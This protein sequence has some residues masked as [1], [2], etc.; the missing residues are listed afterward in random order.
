MKKWLNFVIVAIT[1]L[2]VSIIIVV[3]LRVNTL[4][5]HIE[6]LNNK[7]V[8]MQIF[9]QFGE[10]FTVIAKGGKYAIVYNDISRKVGVIDFC[11]KWLLQPEF[12]N[13][14]YARGIFGLLIIEGE[15]GV[16]LWQLNKGWILEPQYNNILDY[17]RESIFMII[18]DFNPFE[19]D[20]GYYSLEQ[21][22]PCLTN[23]YIHD[24]IYKKKVD[25]NDF[26]LYY[27]T[28]YVTF[29]SEKSQSRGLYSLRTKRVILEP[30]YF[31]IWLNE[32][33]SIGANDCN[34]NEY[35]FNKEGQLLQQKKIE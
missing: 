15:Q 26:M 25:M 18:E 32:N 6:Q 20:E 14:E 9:E 31:S 22:D 16:G 35:L 23:V 13:I 1:A 7:P 19:F 11:G 21:I 5:K 4:N 10:N 12:N 29:L 24:Y 2:L 17:S 8:N 34:N 30:K 33:G 27:P 3:G 28:E